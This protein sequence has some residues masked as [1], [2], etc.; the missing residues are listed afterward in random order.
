[1][2]GEDYVETV[3]EHETWVVNDSYTHMTM[4]PN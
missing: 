1:M 4:P 2:C 3:L